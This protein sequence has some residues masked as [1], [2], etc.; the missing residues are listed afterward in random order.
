MHQHLA[1]QGFPDLRPSQGFA[2]NA[3]GD[4]GAT[5]SELAVV[6]GVTKQAAAKV[7]DGLEDRGYVA[8]R[9]HEED[10]RARSVSL[11]ARGRALLDAAASIQQELEA[12]WAATVGDRQLAVMRRS[13]EQV[14]ASRYG[15]RLPPLRPLW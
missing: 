12:E 1:D 6:L 7:V 5:V 8:R 4:G 2:L 3:V 15:D 13:L 14:L 11:T 10:G 9:A